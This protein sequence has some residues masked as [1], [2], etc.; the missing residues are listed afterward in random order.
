VLKFSSA[1]ERLFGIKLRPPAIKLLEKKERQAKKPVNEYLCPDSGGAT[2]AFSQID[3]N[4]YPYI[5]L[6]ASRGLDEDTIV[7]ELFHL[8]LMVKGFPMFKPCATEGLSPEVVRY[9][10]LARM[11]I[12]SSLQH[13]MFFPEMRNLLSSAREQMIIESTVPGE[14]LENP[15]EISLSV[16]HSGFVSISQLTITEPLNA[17]LMVIVN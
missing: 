10:G 16:D 14:G 9:L 13:Y 7:H 12:D 8:R 3:D 11:V 17:P 6:N 4:G 1:R 2:V 15:S 5:A